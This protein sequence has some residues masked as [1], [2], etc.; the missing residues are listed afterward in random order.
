MACATEIAGEPVVVTRAKDGGLHAFSNVCRHRGA[1]IAEGCGQA[2]VLRCPYHAWTYALDGRLLGQPEFEGVEDWDRA[3]VRLPRFQVATWGPFVFVNQDPEAPPLAEVL[4]AIPRETGESGCPIDH[5]H[6]SYRR[7]YEIQCNWKVYIDNYLEGYHLPAAHPGLY[8]ELDYQ[9]YRVDTNRYY[10][11]QIAPIRALSGEPRRYQFEDAGRSAL[12]YWLFPNF[13][14]NIYPDNLSSNLILPLG[15][16]RTL[17]VFEWFA[18]EG[19]VAQATIDFSDDI[20]REDIRLCESVQRGLRSRHYN[21]G[22]FSVKREN[23]VHHFHGLLCEFLGGT[24][25]TTE[26]RR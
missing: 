14:L 22:R 4:G 15:A 10:S 19:E 8:R 25:F 16:D 20:Q 17:T 3:A 23:G 21:Q 26:T 1:V 7:D 12:Y 2:N 5:L 6:F 24:A 11:S 9:Q 18:Y 13:M